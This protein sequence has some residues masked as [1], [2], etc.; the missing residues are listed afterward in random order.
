MTDCLFC[1][2]Q[3]HENGNTMVHETHTQTRAEIFRA[4][5]EKERFDTTVM[6]RCESACMEMEVFFFFFVSFFG[7]F[8]KKG[9]I[10]VWGALFQPRISEWRCL[11][12]SKCWS[13]ILGG[14][15]K[16]YMSCFVASILY[17][18]CKLLQHC[19]LGLHN[20]YM[21]EYSLKPSFFYN[22]N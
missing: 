1:S 8:H 7:T 20:I 15:A 6:E 16:Y 5:R 3:F 2:L 22:L 9:K 17:E 21:S 13:S 4:E 11:T 10:C 12:F 14:Q 18:A 19:S